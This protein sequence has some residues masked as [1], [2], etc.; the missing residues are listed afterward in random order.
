MFERRRQITKYKRDFH[1]LVLLSTMWRDNTDA[2]FLRNVRIWSIRGAAPTS[3][4]WSKTIES[5]NKFI[6]GDYL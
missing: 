3:A 6:T 2:G 4:L 1:L 5:S